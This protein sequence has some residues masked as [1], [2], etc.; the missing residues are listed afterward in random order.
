MIARTW[1]GRVP[2]A[3]ADAYHD[4][5]LRT[6]VADYAGTPGNH[7]VHV[8]RRVEGEVAHFLLIT[9]WESVE[10]IRR[11]AGEDYERARYYPEDDGFLLE[12]EPFVTHYEVLL[13]AP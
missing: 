4:Y 5:L 11:F 2:A 3:K 1:H 13:A 9:Y 7:G 8:L 12:R 6:G 10:A